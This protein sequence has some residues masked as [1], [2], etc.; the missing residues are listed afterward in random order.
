MSELPPGWATVAL[1]DVSE[2]QGG[3]QK[4]PKRRPVANRYPFLRVA[5]V[6]RGQLNLADV[7]E[8]ELFEGELETF[9]L[10]FGDLLVV[11]G[12][13]S[14]DQLGRAAMWSSEIQ[15]CVHQNH[16]IRVRPNSHLEPRLL[17]LLWN[18]ETVSKQLARVAASTSGLH[19]L[20]VSKLKRI[21]IPVA[22]IE[23][24]RRILAVLEQLLSNLDA[25]RA[26]I[27]QAYRRS[28]DLRGSIANSLLPTGPGG[29]RLPKGW[30]W[31][32]IGDLS[33]ASSYGTSTRCAYDGQGAPVLR[34][35]NVKDGGI[36]QSDLKYAVD[37]TADLSR[38]FIAP[39][40]LL[41]VRT[42]G[43]PGLIGRTAVARH[44]ED[45]A[46]ASYLIRFRFSE[47]LLAEW[48]QLTLGSP[49][50]REMIVTAAATSAGQYNLN[51]RF[52]GNIPI[53]VPPRELMR[54]IV[55][56][57]KDLSG[58]IA[59]ITQSLADKVAS[60]AKYT[61]SL[62]HRVAFDGLLVDQN[63]TDEPVDSL[64]ARDRALREVDTPSAQLG[65]SHTRKA[66]T[67]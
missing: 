27:D 30:T 6:L 36:D 35:P 10:R 24:Q 62:L 49:R 14:P 61:R 64:L 1:A 25:A 19:T 67:A 5:N 34:I 40:D 65:K 48:V 43:S 57:E 45:I 59:R 11:E 31:T 29:G 23:E 53:A 63:P 37:S 8:I 50:W 17:N 21:R 47:T 41:C 39:G 52:L 51:S 42:N 28:R 13:G 7:H 15:D 55:D 22:P 66:T 26:T 12:N 56:Q 32:T 20:S 9:S 54:E 58:S 38:Y 4:Q 18:S 2:I 46:Y 44:T 33:Y 60:R 16:L 3:I